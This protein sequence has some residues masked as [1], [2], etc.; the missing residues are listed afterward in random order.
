MPWAS[1]HAPSAAF[2][3]LV[4]VGTLGLCC[5][6]GS[7]AQD[8]HITGWFQ[9]HRQRAM[10]SRH[11]DLSQAHTLGNRKRTSR[12]VSRPAGPTKKRVDYVIVAATSLAA[13]ARRWKTFREGSGYRVE[14][15]LTRDLAPPGT[16]LRPDGL[17]QGIRKLIAAR[18][19][20]RDPAKPLYVLLLGDGHHPLPS[21]IYLNR[22][23]PIVTDNPYADVDGDGIPEVALGRIPALTDAE[24]DRIRATVQRYESTYRVGPWNRRI[25][26]FAAPGDYGAFVDS[27]IEGVAKDLLEQFS[28]DY[29]IHVLYGAKGSP[30]AYPPH[31]FSDRVYELVN[32]GS[33]FTV[34]IGHGTE[35]GPQYGWW[36]GKSFDIWKVSQLAR[37]LRMVKKPSLLLLLACDMGSFAGQDGIGEKLL[38]HPY[39]SPAVIAATAVSHPYPN[40]LLVQALGHLVTNRRVS[41][42]GV[43]LQQAKT[44]MI[45]H[46]DAQRDALDTLMALISTKAQADH[47]KQ[48]H[49]RMYVLLGDPALKIRY[50]TGRA[51]LR[52]TPR[53]PRPGGQLTVT[54]R[55]DAPA[56]GV[57]R[58]TLETRRK[59]ILGRI[60]K[61]PKDSDPRRDRV[62][63]DNYRV[64]NDKVV[65]TGVVRFTHGR[66]RLSLPIPNSLPPGQYYVKVYAQDGRQDAMGSLAVRIQ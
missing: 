41:T 23:S 47:L 54:A 2:P 51:T 20:A 62:L 16:P 37:K 56:T 48:T 7:E 49:L 18:W 50:V 17:R 5:A 60:Q 40:T 14:L 19:K 22:L 10:A 31:R 29:D 52:L 59:V 28:Y 13:S 55:F 25:N 21:W 33:L 26:L 63:L 43:L 15:V 57:A 1:P 65:S 53:A 6:T 46:R 4:F 64:A 9:E 27:L 3:I 36:N 32:S 42:V 34:Y 11:S 61:L 39:G 66:V 35:T 30:A 12:L 38:R 58:F 8:P 44:R 24:V 45:R